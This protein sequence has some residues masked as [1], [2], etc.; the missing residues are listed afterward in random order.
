MKIRTYK[1]ILYVSLCII[2]WALIPV[3][4]KKVLAG[5]NNFAMLLFSNLISSLTMASY[6]I[7]TKKH[8][9][10]KQYV[11]KDYMYLF[12][13]GFLGT[14]VYYVFLYGAFSFAKAQEVF[15]INYLWPI[16]VILFAIFIF[17]ESVTFIK[18]VSIAISFVGVAVIVSKGNLLSVNFESIKGD[19]LALLGAISFALFSVLG[20]NSK[21]D[22]TVS[23]FVYFLSS[24][25]LSLL[26]IPF[27]KINFIDSSV[28]FWLFVNGIFVNGI[29]YVFWFSAL[30]S[31]NIYVVSNAVYLTPFIALIFINIFLGEKIY[32]Y[33]IVAL[34]L[35]ISGIMIQTVSSYIYKKSKIT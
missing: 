25:F 6:M 2:F 32:S 15:I 4:S 28:I 7:I 27:M 8:Y 30:R 20:K 16:L 14:F 10:M 5:M 23:V 18:L 17:K 24:F 26:F 35:I 19:S 1:Y 31:G 29:S 11:A 3:C 13:L 22:E 34:V 9:I 21:Y 33:S 12:F